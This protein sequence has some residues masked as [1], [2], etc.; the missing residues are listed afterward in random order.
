MY[1]L[2][3]MLPQATDKLV[4][5][6]EDMILKHQIQPQRD[7]V[8]KLLKKVIDL[9]A[10]R[11]IIALTAWTPRPLYRKYFGKQKKKGTKLKNLKKKFKV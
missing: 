10:G 8:T 11:N 2:I 1:K 9:Q 4:M 3:K 6:L 5:V 7:V